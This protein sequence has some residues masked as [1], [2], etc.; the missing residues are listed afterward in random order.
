MKILIC[1]NA[2]PPQT[3]RAA[4]SVQL[5]V[6]QLRSLGHQT[7][8]VVPE[9]DGA[10]AVQDGVIHLPA[11]HGF[12]PSDLAVL[13]P[14]LETALCE[15]EPDVIHA[16]HP[17]LLGGV[18][19]RI[20]DLRK[21]PLVFTH[22][23]R[24]E[25]GVQQ[26]PFDSPVIQRLFS[27]L[28]TRYSNMCDAVVVPT[29]RT[30]AMLRQQGVTSAVTIIPT[31]AETERFV[32]GEAEQMRAEF[33]I[34]QDAFVVGLAADG[35][36]SRWPTVLTEAIS[37]FLTRDRRAHLLLFA[38]D[39][40]EMPLGPR[41]RSPQL[42]VRAHCIECH[43]EA[44]LRAAYAAM[45]VLAACGQRRQDRHA[46]VEALSAG[47]PV[48]AIEDPDSRELVQDGKNGRLLPQLDAGAL[49]AALEW[50]PNLGSSERIAMHAAIHATA[51]RLTLR[52][53]ALRMTELYRHLIEQR[54][55]R[56]AQAREAP[57]AALGWVDEEIKILS[58]MAGALSD[59][60]LRA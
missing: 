28:V 20:A 46:L 3:G 25:C 16:H 47:V 2:Y 39:R 35:G 44:E 30:A 11:F 59:A 41:L 50:V 36:D 8:V 5:H 34:P 56:S 27:D 29:Q 57:S 22:H 58:N 15:F 54:K 38:R 6:D 7:L 49:A 52:E 23:M 24:C 4:R 18:A 21:S 31:G 26:G 9:S 53:S 60:L 42:R 48:I 17:L 40:A 10:P 13:P 1:P 33:G 14:A 55:T 45:D 43:R 12:P 37:S 51:Q 32:Q 19:L